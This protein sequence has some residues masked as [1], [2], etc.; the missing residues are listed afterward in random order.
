MDIWH[1][2]RFVKDT[3][4]SFTSYLERN[5]KWNFDD[6]DE[7]FSYETQFFFLN[8]QDFQL[9]LVTLFAL[10]S[11]TKNSTV[12]IMVIRVTPP[13]LHLKPQFGFQ[14]FGTKV[15]TSSTHSVDGYS[16]LKPPHIIKNL[17]KSLIN[18]CNFWKHKLNQHVCVSS[19]INNSVEKIWANECYCHI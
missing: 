18:S 12:S 11:L 1:D 9:D 3:N 7:A 19:A 13:N 5:F 16:I 15:A 14:I 4:L 17:T 2:P 8:Q 6:I 10:S